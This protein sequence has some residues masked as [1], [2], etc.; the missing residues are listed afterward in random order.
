L[1]AQSWPFML[2]ALSITVYMRIDQIM[3]KAFSGAYEL[4][5]YA[6]ALPLSQI[7]QMIP[8][9]LIISFGPYVAQ[10]KSA[11]EQQYETA[12]LFVFR[13]FMGLS[14]A[15]A[16]L[17]AIAAPFAIPAIYGPKF[18]ASVSVLQ[19]HVFSNVCIA[20]AMAQ[21]L[22]IT[23]ENRSQLLLVQTFAGAA[24]A[25]I[26][27]WLIIPIWGANGAAAVAILAQLTSGMLVN[28]IAAPELFLLQLGFQRHK[29]AANNTQ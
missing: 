7:W 24:V 18:L 5:I 16:L 14:F 26:G 27:N 10:K 1:L 21:C 13:L 28:A 9:T 17:T 11:G 23:N 15:A 19:I 22:W 20:I 2:S 8:M 12:L 3:L 4:G 29:A 6:A 25:V